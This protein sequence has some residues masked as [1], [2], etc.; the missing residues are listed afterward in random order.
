MEMTD[1]LNNLLYPLI[2]IDC[3]VSGGI[4]VQNLDKSLEVY[5]LKHSYRELTHQFLTHSFGVAFVETQS[6]RKI[7]T[8]TGRW[9][10]IHKLCL[11]HQRIQD[12]LEQCDIKHF[13]LTAKEWQK[14]LSLK[15]KNYRDRKK[16]LKQIAIDKFPTYKVTN[17][18]CDCL[19]MM[20]YIKNKF[21]I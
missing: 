20:D 13:D 14:P 15:S 16:E 18:N 19:L 1:E 2:T 12:S 8:L 5:K 6:L 11:H 9:H 4:V 3:G 21:K 7:D 17:W 10:N